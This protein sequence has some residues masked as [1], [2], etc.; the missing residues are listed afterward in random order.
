M[1]EVGNEQ[2]GRQEARREVPYIQLSRLEA[3][4]LTIEKDSEDVEQFLLQE[5]L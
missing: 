3:S 2:R 5:S 4:L 1:I